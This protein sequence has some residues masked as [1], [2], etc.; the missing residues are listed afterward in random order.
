MS[1]RFDQLT[2]RH[3]N[4]L[5]SCAV[6]RQQLAETAEEIEHELGRLD[7]G[8]EIVRGVLHSP[9]TL[10]A[11]IA[12]VAAVG[13]RRLLRWGTRALMFYTTARRLIELR[14]DASA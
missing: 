1:E 5:A 7:R 14:R 13:P 2:A 9:A 10:G 4:L 8:I 11:A 6:Q 3:S 12:I